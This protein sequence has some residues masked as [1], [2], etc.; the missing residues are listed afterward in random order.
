MENNFHNLA[1]KPPKSEDPGANPSPRH[2]LPQRP[3]HSQSGGIAETD[4]GLADPETQLQP[5]VKGRQQENTVGQRG[6]PGAQGPEQIVAQAQHQTDRKGGGDPDRHSLWRRHWNIL[7][8][9]PPFSRS[10]W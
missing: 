8:S 10:S 5:A 6:A 9:Q 3:S 4:I 1:A 2:R 7:R